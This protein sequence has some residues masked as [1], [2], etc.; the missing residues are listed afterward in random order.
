MYISVGKLR[1]WQLFAH[2]KEK[3]NG[4]QVQKEDHIN[5]IFDIFK[6]TMCM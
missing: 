3:L 2:R 1:D 6:R 4:I 5:L